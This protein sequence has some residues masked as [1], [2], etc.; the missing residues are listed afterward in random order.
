[1]LEQLSRLRT[2]LHCRL[3]KRDVVAAD[4]AAAEGDL[5]QSAKLLDK[6]DTRLKR[7]C[8]L[9]TWPTNRLVGPPPR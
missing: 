3:A 1:M 5:D 8:G 2:H 6:A 9:S 7:A 4:R